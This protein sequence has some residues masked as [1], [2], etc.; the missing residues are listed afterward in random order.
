MSGPMAGHF[1]WLR[2]FCQN[3]LQLGEAGEG[4]HLGQIRLTLN[5]RQGVLDELVV[6][7]VA[8]GIDPLLSLIHISEPTRR[9]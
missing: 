7:A 1:L 6:H 9:S 3:F 2:L 5:Q 8:L 4:V